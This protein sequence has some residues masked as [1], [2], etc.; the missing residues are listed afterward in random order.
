MKI[1]LLIEFNA[2]DVSGYDAADGSV[3]AIPSGTSDYSYQWLNG[4][5]SAE[6]NGLD[7]GSYSVTVTDVNGCTST[8][9]VSIDQPN[10]DVVSF[11]WSTDNLVVESNN[12]STPGDYLWD[13]GDGNTSS[14]ANPTYYLFRSWH[15]YCLFTTLDRLWSKRAL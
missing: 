10:P 7:V 15:L 6:W 13:F 1:P 12:N 14:D 4:P 5:A 8:N 2:V 3:T 9:T 11:S